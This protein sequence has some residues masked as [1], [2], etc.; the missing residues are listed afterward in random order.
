MRN[1]SFQAGRF[2]V[3]RNG[4]D[5]RGGA[6]LQDRRD[7]DQLDFGSSADRV[8]K[9]ED[10]RVQADP[11]GHDR[12]REDAVRRSLNEGG[13]PARPPRGGTLK[14]ARLR[15]QDLPNLE[16]SPTSPGTLRLKIGEL[17]VHSI[18]A[19]ARVEMVNRETGE[20]R[21]ALLGTLDQDDPISR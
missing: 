19:A 7:A 15:I 20:Y 17:I 21:V 1:E 11:A 6:A 16:I 8:G 3:A 14:M 13:R 10:G 4:A 2:P 9:P 18:S 12:R 5:L